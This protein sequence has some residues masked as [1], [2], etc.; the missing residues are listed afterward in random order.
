MLLLQSSL[1]LLHFVA[2]R[3]A[4]LDFVFEVV[5]SLLP[6]SLSSNADRVERPSAADLPVRVWGMAA[7]G[8]PFA[9][10]ALLRN[11]TREGAVITGLSSEIAVGE[12]IGVQYEERKARFRVVWTATRQPNRGH[13]EIRLLPG[14]ECP[15]EDQLDRAQSETARLDHRE[16]R[17]Y[18]TF[19]PIEL[20]AT[21]CDAP[22][23]MAATDVSGSGCYVQ[24]MV[25][26]KVG[27]RL[28]L[29]FWLEGEK[30]S[31]ECTVRTCDAG[32]GMGI[33][34]TGLEPA[35]KYRLQARLDRGQICQSMAAGH[36]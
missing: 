35:T 23:R 9:Q 36:K 33:E 1:F 22:M 31:C 34:F 29:S 24:I 16:Y 2:K 20:C 30:I 5:M 8:R 19:F 15:W 17:R 18:Q 14:Q 21:E 12:I 11:R 6:P 26:A 7:D 13:A 3:R 4:F 32:F 25:P 28:M 10:N 27:T